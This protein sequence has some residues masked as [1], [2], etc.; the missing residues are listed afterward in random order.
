MG[1]LF[2]CPRRKEEIYANHLPYLEGRGDA[3]DPTGEDDHRYYDVTIDRQF[4]SE[5]RQVDLR[6]SS[7]NCIAAEINHKPQR[8]VRF[9]FACRKSI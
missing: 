5:D 4:R 9:H 7:S 2:V 6:E 1:Q 8:P 3:D